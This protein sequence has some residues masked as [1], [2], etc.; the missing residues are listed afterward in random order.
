MNVLYE[1]NSTV[2]KG[3]C[4][5]PVDLSIAAGPSSRST[6]VLSKKQ[7]CAKTGLSRATIDRMVRKA[8][9]PRPIRLTSRRVG[10]LESVVD[11]W[12]AERQ[13]LASALVG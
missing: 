11:E 12:L 9:F 4:E 3:R 13:R 7:I 10:W 6:R 5:D 8:E 1:N 2:L